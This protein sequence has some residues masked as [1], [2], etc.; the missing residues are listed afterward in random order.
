[1]LRVLSGWGAASG[2]RSTPQLSELLLILPDCKAEAPSIILLGNP[3]QNIRVYGMSQAKCFPFPW[4]WAL[5][6]LLSPS[7]VSYPLQF[8]NNLLFRTRSRFALTWFLLLAFPL[9]LYLQA[10]E[11]FPCQKICTHLFCSG[12]LLTIFSSW[13]LTL[14][15]FFP[16]LPDFEWRTLSKTGYSELVQRG[17]WRDWYQISA[18][19]LLHFL[20]INTLFSC[21]RVSTACR[22]LFTCWKF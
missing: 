22:V 14:I 13:L 12:I 21:Y 9:T 18:S 3:S 19:F 2:S 4:S 16:F 1:M 6:C 20:D 7:L 11:F 15:L 10:F 8:K 5:V 17:L